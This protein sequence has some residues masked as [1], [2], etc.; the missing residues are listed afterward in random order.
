MGIGCIG[1]CDAGVKECP[2]HHP[3]VFN[4]PTQWILSLFFLSPNDPQYEHWKRLS[5]VLVEE[6]I[7]LSL[8]R[9]RGASDVGDKS[10]IDPRQKNVRG[11]LGLPL[12]FRMASDELKPGDYRSLMEGLYRVLNER[13]ADL[14]RTLGSDLVPLKKLMERMIEIGHCAERRSDPSLSISV[15]YGW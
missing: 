6:G 7:S 8:L 2:K 15:Y 5:E 11:A 4:P 10:G 9:P 12:G 1:N 13:E 3:P 14:V